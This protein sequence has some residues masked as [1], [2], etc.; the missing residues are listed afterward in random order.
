MTKIRNALIFSA[1]TAFGSHAV[2][3]DDNFEFHGY[4]RAGTGGNSEGGDQVCF[5]VPGAKAKYRLGNE[6]EV[7]SEIIFG[8]HAFKGDDGAFFDLKTNIAF[9]TQGEEDF[10]SLSDPGDNGPA[11]R[12]AYVQGGNLL[13]G[14]FE[15]AS[16][17]VGKR[18]YRRHDVHI[19][20]FF[21]WDASGAGGGVEDID[22]GFGKLAYAYFRNSNDEVPT[23]AVREVDPVTGNPLSDPISGDPIVRTITGDRIQVNDRAVSRHDFRIY[24]I[25]SNPGGQLTL[26]ADLRISEEDRGNFDGEDGYAFHVMHVQNDVLGGDNKIALQYGKGSASTLAAASDDTND[27]GHTWRITESLL[28]EPSPGWSLAG[29]LIYE[30]REDTGDDGTWLSVGGRFKKYMTDYLNLVLE[31]G[32]DQF[33]P[34][35]GESRELWKIT[36]AVALSAGRGFY[37]RPTLRL[38]ATYADWNAA[39]RDAG[40][41]GGSSGV[42]GLDTEGFTYGVQAEIWW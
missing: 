41:A 27:D 42:Y 10:E 3:A 22:L 15:G 33:D 2:W 30:D 36:P 8:Y 25:D 19:N 5:Q 1:I 18:F 26:G 6:C 20:D 12:E 34:D 29:T 13:G 9:V 40:L 16:F 17:W 28:V 7:Y 24:G 32:Y 21:F 37:A 39:A 38:F 11:F 31:V 35:D 23:F 14:V 4:L